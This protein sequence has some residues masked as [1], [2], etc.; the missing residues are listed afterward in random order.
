MEYEDQ[1]TNCNIDDEVQQDQQTKVKDEA[2]YADGNLD[3][4]ENYPTSVGDPS[5]PQQV[6]VP[7]D[8][9]QAIV[10]REAKR[11]RLLK[12]VL[13]QDNDLEESVDSVH[14]W[15]IEYE[16]KSISL[17]SERFIDISQ[18]L[19][20]QHVNDVKS[21]SLFS[22][23]AQKK[24][25]KVTSQ[26]DA[27]WN[28]EWQTV[29]HPQYFALQTFA[30]MMIVNEKNCICVQV[31]EF[32]NRQEN[33]DK[34]RELSN[35]SDSSYPTE[36]KRQIFIFSVAKDLY[37]QHKP[38]IP[39]DVILKL[40]DIITVLAPDNEYLSQ[41]QKKLVY[42]EIQAQQSLMTLKGLGFQASYQFLSNALEAPDADA[43][44]TILWNYPQSSDLDILE[45]QL[46]KIIRYVLTDFSNKCSRPS[47]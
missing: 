21:N 30:G 17:L 44:E 4:E 45:K 42:N 22:D 43:L 15:K 34:H 46:I 29:E 6:I 7:K 38:K 3:D 41:N 24:Y 9:P 11:R 8:D 47:A 27:M 14:D 5:V 13:P 31:A 40:K 35:I 37:S 25:V 1:R 18:E 10:N 36:S 26:I 39:V 32:Y 19:Y 12:A 33:I 2:Q 23:E 28:Q 16:D 20:P